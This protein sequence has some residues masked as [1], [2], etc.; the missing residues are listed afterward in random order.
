MGLQRQSDRR[1]WRLHLL[2]C[3]PGSVDGL[4][5]T[6][7]AAITPWGR[8]F[9]QGRARWSWRVWH[10]SDGKVCLHD[11]VKTGIRAETGHICINFFTSRFKNLPVVRKILF[12]QYLAV[13]AIHRRHK[14]TSPKAGFSS[15]RR[16][17]SHAV[18]RDHGLPDCHLQA[19]PDACAFRSGAR[20]PCCRGC[21][22]AEPLH[23]ADAPG[24]HR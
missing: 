19:W 5:H 18:Y 12:V 2:F 9:G 7:M 23:A 16:P 13:P 24:V 17:I 4:L 11:W 1:T 10:I 8:G 6:A 3:Q 22:Y 20:P 14:K 21:F 15:P